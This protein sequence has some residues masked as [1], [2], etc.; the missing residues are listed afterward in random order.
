MLEK[1]LVHTYMPRS[2]SVDDKADELQDWLN[3]LEGKLFSGPAPFPENQ[4][5]WWAVTVVEHHPL[6]E[7][8]S[9]HA[10]DG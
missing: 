9:M 3:T 2:I 7:Q 1:R 8:F 4:K 6:A 10:A 5:V